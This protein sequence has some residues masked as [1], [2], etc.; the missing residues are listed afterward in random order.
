MKHPNP[1]EWVAYLYR[2]VDSQTRSRLEDHLAHCESCRTQIEQWRRAQ[3]HL[4]SWQLPQRAVNPPALR[5]YPVLVRWAAA[6]ILMLALGFALGRSSGATSPTTVAA[7][8][9]DLRGELAEL[10]KAQV[11][12]S[13]TAT[14]A[15]AHDHTA[16]AMREFVE[17][18]QSDRSADH[19]KIASL[20]TRLDTARAA[21]Y[22]SLR[23][24]LETVALNSDVGLRQTRQQLVRLADY[25]QANPITPTN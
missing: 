20:L 7:L 12:E 14:L 8:R 22:L 24:D 21:D 6:A 16:A 11:A 9:E 3:Q 19:Q 4:D 15:A 2:E 18:Y 23:K 1:Q 17:L 10:L 13:T 25:S 5:P